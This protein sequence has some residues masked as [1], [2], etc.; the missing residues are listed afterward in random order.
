MYDYFCAKPHTMIPA[1]HYEEPKKTDS[2]KVQWEKVSE[3]IVTGSWN[4]IYADSEDAFTAIVSSMCAGANACGYEECVLWCEEEAE[5]RFVS[6][7]KA[8]E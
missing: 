8:R 6:E 7:Q 3:C 1:T 2:L 4:A 5:K